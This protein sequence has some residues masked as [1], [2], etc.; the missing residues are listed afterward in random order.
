MSDL[1]YEVTTWFSDFLEPIPV[2]D[3]MKS[4]TDRSFLRS[5]QQRGH[6]DIVEL[7]RWPA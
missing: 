6:E 1:N 7:A 5:L 4:S 2:P 3:D